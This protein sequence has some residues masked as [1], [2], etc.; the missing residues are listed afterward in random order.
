MRVL[1]GEGNPASCGTHISRLCPSEEIIQFVCATFQAI[2]DKSHTRT[3]LSCEPDTIHM[4][5]LENMTELTELVWPFSSLSSTPVDASHTRTELSSESSE[6]DTIRVPSLENATA[7]IRPAA[8]ILINGKSI[9]FVYVKTGMRLNW[10][11]QFRERMVS[12][13]HVAN[14]E[15]Y[16]CGVD[17]AAGL[18]AK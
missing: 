5:S 2:I 8:D 1:K 17:L 12:C 16:R 3:D 7:V 14:A 13:D 6:P 15:M 4:P 10:F 9:L 18:P 11:F